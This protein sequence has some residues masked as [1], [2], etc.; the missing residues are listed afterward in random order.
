M[1]K[2]IV[3]L[4]AAAMLL[5]L[6]ACTQN[7]ADVDVTTT[8]SSGDA[9]PDT[10]AED[11]AAQEGTDTLDDDYVANVRVLGGPT[12]M[13]IAKL[14]SDSVEGKT[15]GH[16]SFSVTASPDTEYLTEIRK[17]EFDIAALPTNVAAKLYNTGAPIQIAA[18]NT[19][20][21]LYVMQVGEVTVNSV[22]DLA[23][24]TIYTTGEG[25][26]PEYALRYILSKN[27]IDPDKEVTIIYE[28]EGT[29]VVADIKKGDADIVMIPEPLAT[30]LRLAGTASVVLDVTEEWN[31]VTD[32]KDTLIQG[33]MVVSNT[34]ASEHKA[35]LN[36]FLEEYKSSIEYVNANHAQAGEL[37]YSLEIITVSSSVA[38]AAIDTSKITYMDGDGMKS[39]L[40]ALYGILLSSD[41][42]SVGGKVPDENFYYK[43]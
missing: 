42:T 2:I 19:L 43:K 32:E 17:G 31:K 12:G 1:K 9:T 22:S 21:V 5:A 6:A 25:A 30:N 23:G 27:G 35:L 41:A 8:A 3:F 34:F 4:L 11:D 26:T 13:G 7:S 20:G 40:S 37:I 14:W 39:S 38:E 29:G 28:S 36:K 15:E 18:V 33:C 24:K 16:Y 10:G